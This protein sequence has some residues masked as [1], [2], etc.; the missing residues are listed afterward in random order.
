MSQKLHGQRRQNK[1]EK[2]ESRGGRRNKPQD[3]G[4]LNMLLHI[5]SA[6]Q[7]SQCLERKKKNTGRYCAYLQTRGTIEI[8]L[9]TQT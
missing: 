5:G 8:I 2:R 6:E 9:R 1:G 7:Q 4:T 3:T